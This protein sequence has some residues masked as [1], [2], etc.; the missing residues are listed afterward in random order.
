MSV[1]EPSAAGNANGTPAGPPDWREQAL[2]V[3]ERL[4]QRWRD[5]T[6][7]VR[8]AGTTYIRKGWNVVFFPADKKGPTTKGWQKSR[9]EENDLDQHLQKDGYWNIGIL[10]GEPSGGLVDVDLDAPQAV[11]V[12]RHFL[13]QTDR[14]HGRP[15][16]PSSHFWFLPDGRLVTTKFPDVDGTMLVEVRSTGHQTMVPP[17]TH[18]KTHERVTW[19]SEGDPAKVNGGELLKCVGKVAA[20]AILARHWPGEGSR[21]DAAM[22]LSGG[23]LDAGWEVEEAEVLLEAVGVAAGDE[24]KDKRVAAVRHTAKAREEG[25]PRT[26]WTRLGTLLGEKG[27]EVVS[28]VQKWLGASGR[29]PGSAARQPDRPGYTSPLT[30]SQLLEMDLPEPRWAVEG[31]CAE[32]LS[33]LAG[34]PK[35]GKS[36]LALQ[37][38]W[39]VAAGLQILGRPA[40]AGE[41]LAIF[42]EDNPRRMKK[43]L[44]KLLGGKSPPDNFYVQHAW[45]RQDQG[46]LEALEKWL[47]RHPGTRLVIIDTWKKFRPAAARGKNAY[48]EDYEAAAALQ[49]LAQRYGVAILLLHHTRKVDHDEDFVDSVSGSYGFTGA[50]DGILVLRRRRSQDE[51][52][53]H[54]T[55]RD[56]EEE[57]ELALGWDGNK[58]TWSLLGDAREVSMSRQRQ[59][60]ISLLAQIGEP[61]TPTEVATLTDRKVGSVKKMM[62]YM[63]KA[64]QIAAYGKGTYTTN[65]IA[66]ALKEQEAAEGGNP[67]E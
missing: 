25:K 44:G 40:Q 22:A 67:E 54:V 41:V 34:K 35:V 13:P 21:Q 9:L 27:P 19:E 55:G 39:A 62:W 7:Q 33:A 15:G 32:G 24:E 43:R 26:G 52:I 48:D 45:P 51:G 3:A 30:A 65:E 1:A 64:G 38:A 20:A 14:V 4:R 50:L 6:E 28:R 46:G 11:A 5:R 18:P 36:W 59:E 49:E 42:L 63:G 23:L 61:S 53:L 47:R 57:L 29:G 60:I 8:Q 58:A 37:L 17:S 56:V 31:L 16:K 12:A 2:Q 66:L 10:T